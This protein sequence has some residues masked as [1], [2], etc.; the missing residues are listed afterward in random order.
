MRRAIRARLVYNPAGVVSRC[1]RQ[2]TMR[3][4]GATAENSRSGVDMVIPARP[5]WT[6]A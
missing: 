6:S 2:R 1:S 5:F 3:D 4:N